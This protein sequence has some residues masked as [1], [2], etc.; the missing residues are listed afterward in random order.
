MQIEHQPWLPT[1]DEGIEGQKIAVIGYSHY[2]DGPDRTSTTTDVLKAV[3]Q[4]SYRSQ[5][6][7]NIQDYFGFGSDAS[8]WNKVIFFNFLP[9]A[10]GPKSEKYAI[11]TPLQLKR[12]RDRFIRIM[13]AER[14][15]KVF[16]FTSKGWNEFPE[17]TLEEI[18]GGRCNPLIQ[19][20][21]K[22]NWGT[23]LAGEHH[24]LVCGFR[25]PLFARRED[26][27]EQVQAFLKLR[28]TR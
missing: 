28:P 7:E 6:F 4:G 11:G 19:G 26:M 18:S 1:N 16:V 3:V 13:D 20:S 8:F 9:D 24:V 25:H 17:T 2:V 23:Y 22:P 14:P 5:F 12:G 27:R 10:I 21:E 15:E